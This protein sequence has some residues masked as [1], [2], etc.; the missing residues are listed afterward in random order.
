LFNGRLLCGQRACQ[1]RCNNQCD[2]GSSQRIRISAT[3]AVP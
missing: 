3:P 2:R 1:Q